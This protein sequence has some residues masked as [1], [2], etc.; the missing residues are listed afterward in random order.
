M[1][2]LHDSIIIIQ[3]NRCGD[4]QRQLMTKGKIHT[5][6]FSK[7]NQTHIITGT[8]EH[9]KAIAEKYNMQSVIVNEP[10]ETA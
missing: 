10:E 6:K 9:V 3:L 2:A 8:A 5:L 7:G 4:N 1:H